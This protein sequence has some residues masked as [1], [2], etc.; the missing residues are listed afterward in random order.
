MR[1]FLTLRKR[2][3]YLWLG[4]LLLGPAACSPGEAV[5]P[6]TGATDMPGPD[7][8]LAIDGD[9]IGS[10]IQEAAQEA[11]AWLAQELG[12]SVEQIQIV[13]AER[14]EWPNTCLGLPEAGE[15]CA[16]V[17]TPGWHVVVEVNGKHYEVRANETATVVRWQEIQG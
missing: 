17:V 8:T 12:V 6:N 2:L 13:S 7:A 10:A 3:I 9:Q 15:G 1:V 5:L 14:A 16:D 4:A 11:Q